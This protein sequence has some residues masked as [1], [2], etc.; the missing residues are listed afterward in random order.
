[1]NSQLLT[2]RFDLNSAFTLGT[3]NNGINPLIENV[4]LAIGPFVVTIPPGSFTRN[5]Q[6]AYVFQGTI[7]G[8]SLQFRN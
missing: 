7:N 1:L 6:G 8:V 5:K 2:G 4:T 3:G